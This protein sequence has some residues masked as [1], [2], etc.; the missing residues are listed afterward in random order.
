[1]QQLSP[2]TQHIVFANGQYSTPGANIDALVTRV[3]LHGNGATLQGGDTD[4]PTLAVRVP[5]TIRDLV[6][7]HV[8]NIG[9]TA[10]RI[11]APTVADNVKVRGF[12][13][14]DARGQ[15]D[16]NDLN[17]TALDVG[18][19]GSAPLNF[20]RVKIH[21]GRRGLETFNTTVN[22]TNVVVFDT[23][24]QG[25]S[26]TST[27]GTLRFSTI[28]QTGTSNGTPFGISCS[29]SGVIIQASIIWKA[30]ATA[31]PISGSCSQFPNTIAGPP[32]VSGAMN[33][34]PRFQAEVVFEFVLGADSPARDVVDAGPSQ[35]VDRA[36]RPR[37]ARFDVG[38]FEAP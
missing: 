3:F 7:A 14:I 8:S 21:G 28:S 25:I 31:A 20:E 16:A 26:F 33:V 24:E 1:M 29:S 36:L 23:R 34:D 13:A 10:L 37:G 27:D 38:A 17:V 9:G 6:I 35:D 15:L 32:V 2:S 30:N 12:T 18:V 11:L 4:N 22:L 5:T 19:V